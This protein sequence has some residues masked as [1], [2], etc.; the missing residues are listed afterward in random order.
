[1][2]EKTGEGGMGAGSVPCSASL[3]Y[4]TKENQKT[5]SRGPDCW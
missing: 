5:E 3:D 4:G 1:M 2:V